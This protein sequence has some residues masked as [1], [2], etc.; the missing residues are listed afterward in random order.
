MLANKGVI[1]AS[2]AGAVIVVVTIIFL[3]LP[4][5]ID[6]ITPSPAVGADNNNGSTSI[7]FSDEPPRIMLVLLEGP[8]D[9]S[10]SVAEYEANN[11]YPI[12]LAMGAHIRF[13]SPDHRT[14]ESI[15]VVARNLDTGQIELL[16]KSYDVNNEFFINIDKGRYELQ[17]HA[18]WF[19]KGSFVYAF[20]ILVV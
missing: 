7:A 2:A 4:G 20:D 14:A 8:E 10:T 16:R 5:V 13:E 17:V 1:A 11:V 9:G 3:L 18:S 12:E 15:R 6:G 19:E